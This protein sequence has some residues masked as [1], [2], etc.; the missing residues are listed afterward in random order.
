MVGAAEAAPDGIP[1]E[2]KSADPAKPAL[3]KAAVSSIAASDLAEFE[4]LPTAVQ[5]LIRAALALT[6]R[7]LTYRFGSADPDLGGMDCSGTIYYLLRS[8]KR[9]EVP[10]QSNHIGQW[11]IDHSTWHGAPAD[12]QW[13]EAGL[14]A[15]QPGDLLFWSGTY[16]HAPRELPISHVMLYLGRHRET[17]KRL[18]FGASDGR[19]Y[20]G[21]ARCGVSVFDFTLPRPESKARFFGYGRIPGIAQKSI[22]PIEVRKAEP[23]TP[24]TA[25]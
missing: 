20:N 24:K 8:Q 2:K 21:E 5:S 6:Q 22:P 25:S 9:T 17:G 4:E 3:K 12:G 14:E 7:Q 11:V 10:R 1:A 16:E 15:L 19:R 13:S 23:A 18:M